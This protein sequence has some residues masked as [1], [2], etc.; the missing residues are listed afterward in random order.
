[1]LSLT[2]LI[3]LDIEYPRVGAIRIDA[4]DRV[5]VELRATMN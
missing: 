5:M 2:V 3:I 1:M 4:W